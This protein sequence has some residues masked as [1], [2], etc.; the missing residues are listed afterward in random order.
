LRNIGGD[1]IAK[2]PQSFIYF[3]RSAV[4]RRGLLNLF[5]IPAFGWGASWCFMPMSCDPGK[6]QAMAALRVLMTL[7]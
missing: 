1:G 5:P 3:H 6:P 4:G 2:G 7:V